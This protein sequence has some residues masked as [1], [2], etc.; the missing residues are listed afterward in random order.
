MSELDIQLQRLSTLDLTVRNYLSAVAAFEQGAGNDTDVERLHDE[1]V[2]LTSD[3]L[4]DYAEE[5]A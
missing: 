5:I 1:L 2:D 4:F 3:E